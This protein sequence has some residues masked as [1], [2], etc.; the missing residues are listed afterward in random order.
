MFFIFKLVFYK[1]TLSFFTLIRV[2]TTIM[3]LIEFL[4]L[5]FCDSCT[6]AMSTRDMSMPT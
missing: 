6:A 4:L 5:L 1:K 3:L 2:G